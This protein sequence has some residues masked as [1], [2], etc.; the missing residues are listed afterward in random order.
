MS[1]PTILSYGDSLLRHGNVGKCVVWLFF[2]AALA[3]KIRAD[4]Y[5]YRH[6]DAV[7]LCKK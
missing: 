6:F 7:Q 2:Q 5:P 4:P 1:D 3:I